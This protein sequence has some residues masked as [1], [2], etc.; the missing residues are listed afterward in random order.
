MRESTSISNII[1]RNP[2]K[3]T[4]EVFCLHELL[5]LAL[6]PIQL[7]KKGQPIQDLEPIILFPLNRVEAEV[8]NAEVGELL[9][10]T[11]FLD[12]PDLVC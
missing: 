3:L 4:E 6:H 2:A 10:E 11:N 5:G 8:D 1:S 9:D 12:L 7:P